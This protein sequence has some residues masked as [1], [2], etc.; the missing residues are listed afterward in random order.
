[1]TDAK[2]AA[3]AAANDHI[4]PEW[5][6]RWSEAVQFDRALAG[7]AQAAMIAAVY[8]WGATATNIVA[9]SHNADRYKQLSAR[10]LGIN[11]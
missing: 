7:T 3:F 2:G 6:R 8:E 5:Q 11:W 9:A 4:S 1:M 10:T